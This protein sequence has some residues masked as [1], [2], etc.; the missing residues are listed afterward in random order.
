MDLLERKLL[1]A[2]IA[3]DDKVAWMRS[4]IIDHRDDLPLLQMCER[5]LQRLVPALQTHLIEVLFDYRPGEWYPPATVHTPPDRR[6]ASRESNA[7]LRRIGEQALKTVAMDE[8]LR[9]K[10]ELFLDNRQLDSR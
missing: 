7:S 2:T 4:P 6:R 3:E 10:V 5:V 9:K 1:D 8:P